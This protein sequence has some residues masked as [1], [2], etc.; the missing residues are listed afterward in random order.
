MQANPLSCY[1]FL[2]V[3]YTLPKPVG[4]IVPAKNYNYCESQCDQF[5]DFLKFLL[6]NVALIFGDF[7]F[8]LEKHLFK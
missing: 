5:G 4:N 6:T 7:L 1:Y 8:F 3:L 2:I